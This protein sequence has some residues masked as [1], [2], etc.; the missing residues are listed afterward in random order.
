MMVSNT[1][2]LDRKHMQII[3]KKITNRLPFINKLELIL[4]PVAHVSAFFIDNPVR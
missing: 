3:L 1:G 4:F 2:N